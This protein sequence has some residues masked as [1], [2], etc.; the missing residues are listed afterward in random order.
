MKGGGGGVQEPNTFHPSLNGAYKIIN[1][2]NKYR[3]AKYV[4]LFLNNDQIIGYR[5]WQKEKDFFLFM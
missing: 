3:A 2:G 4:L 5:N 1:I